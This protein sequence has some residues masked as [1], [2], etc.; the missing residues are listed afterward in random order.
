MSLL[1]SSGTFQGE[2]R[3]NVLQAFVEADV[4]ARRGREKGG[5]RRISGQPC[6]IDWPCACCGW[7]D[8][9]SFIRDGH[10]QR[11]VQTS[12]GLLSDRRVPMVEC[13]HGQH[14]VVCH[15]AMVEKHQRLWMDLDP[16]VLC[17]SGFHER[18]RQLPERRSAT[19]EGRVGLRTL[20]ERMTRVE[21][22]VTS[23]HQEPIIDGPPVI[24]RDGIRVTIISHQEQSKADTR[25][26]Q[27]TLRPG[28]TM[29]ILVAPGLWPDGRR[30]ILAWQVACCEDH[31]EWDV[32]VQRRWERGCHPERGWQRVVRDGSGG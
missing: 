21:L 18:V 24:Q 10:A 9:H 1:F 16:D 11:R 29:V 15:G 27:R 17:G 32:L 26:R 6:L 25:Q 7:T 8:A 3:T 14:H 30:E 31:R 28:R 4:S 23:A 20:H 12:R 5:S 2:E 19:R 22:L 13:Q